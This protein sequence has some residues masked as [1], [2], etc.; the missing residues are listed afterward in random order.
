MKVTRAT[1]QQLIVADT[2]W[3]IGIM[4]TIFILLFAGIGVAMVLEGEP[5]G[6]LFAIVGGGLGLGG[7]AAFVRR[8]QVILDRPSDTIIIRRRSLFG[9]S[10][11]RHK[12]SN[13]GRAELQMSAGS[14]GGMLYRP[15][16]V[17]ERGMSAGHHPIVQSY[18]NTKGPKRLVDAVNDWL[19]SKA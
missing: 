18:T 1:P 17:L 3:F 11:I 10:E 9:Y 14:K 5:A 16:L 2:P 15:A 4:L 13:L 7:F 6:F 19:D 8:V 12:L